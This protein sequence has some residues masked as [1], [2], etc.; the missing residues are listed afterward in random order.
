MTYERVPAGRGPDPLRHQLLLRA[1]SPARRRRTNPWNANTLEWAAASPPPHGN[2]G[3]TLPTVYRGPYEYS[4]ARADGGLPAA[5]AGGRAPG[6]A[7][8]GTGTEPAHGDQGAPV[9]GG[10]AAPA[11]VLTAAATFVLIVFGGLVTNTGAALAVPDWPTTFGHNMFLFPWSEMVGGVLYEHSH[12]LLGAGVGLLTLALAGALAL[13]EGRR[14]VRGLGVVA[15]L[16]VC[17]QGVVGGLRVVLLQ[18]TLAIVHGWLA[19]AFFALVV[20]LALVT[21]RAWRRRRRR[22]RARGGS[23]RSGR[24]RS[25]SST[26]RSS[27]ARSSRTPAGCPAPGRRGP[28]RASWSGRTRRAPRRR[29]RRGARVVGAGA[30]DAAGRCSSSSASGPTRSGSRPSRCRAGSS[31]C[32]RC[33]S[34]IAWSARSSSAPPSSWPSGSPAGGPCAPAPPADGRPWCRE[35]C[36][37]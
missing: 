28:A 37:A 5:V 30:A 31:P 19:Q 8:P 3:P 33:R 14:W 2:W 22:R 9:T 34:R 27:S 15:V 17:A 26:S 25:R 11:G 7:R 16:L 6:P 13:G 29:R 4:V 32:W 18:D 35:R 24:S 21:G 23:C 36:C 10:L 20:L 1:C 12:R